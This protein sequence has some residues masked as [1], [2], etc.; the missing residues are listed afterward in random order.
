[1]LRDCKRWLLALAAAAYPFNIF[2][3][4]LCKML[5]GKGLRVGGMGI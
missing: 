1:M 5:M 4:V 3:V 2:F